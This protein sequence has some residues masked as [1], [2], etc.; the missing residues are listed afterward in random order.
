VAW[1]N[2]S[3][4]AICQATGLQ[5]I[6][7]QIAEAM[8]DWP[9]QLAMVV[10]V[11]P[12]L[13]TYSVGMPDAT[14]SNTTVTNTDACRI[15]HLSTAA[16]NLSVHCSHGSINGA[17]LCGD[18]TW[19]T[20]KMIMLGCPST[21]ATIGACQAAFAPYFSGMMIGNPC[22][23][24]MGQVPADDSITCRVYYATTALMSVG[25]GTTAPS[26]VCMNTAILGA[27]GCN[28]SAIMAP[29]MKSSAASV[30]LF[31]GLAFFALFW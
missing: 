6:Y 7:G 1:L 23:P 21:F 17:G 4:N 28:V 29:T 31:G 24:M 14:S 19:T 26:S 22:G 25:R 12:N 18:P 10:P 2:I 3:H 27:T 20:C 11:S 15:Y 8:A 5:Y 9:T 16:S 13:A 30:S